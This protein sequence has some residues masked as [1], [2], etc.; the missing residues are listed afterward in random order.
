MDALAHIAW[1]LLF[2]WLLGAALTLVAL[3][4][5]KLL[6]PA[7]QDDSDLRDAPAVSVLVPARDE[8]RRVLAACLGSILAQDYPAF[9]VVAVD[10]RS[11]DATPFI[12]RQVAETDSRL[13]VV[14]GAEPPAGWL[15]KPHALR[16]ALDAADPS[17]EWLLL[18]DADMI[19]HPSA[20]RAAVAR[21]RAARCDALTLVPR[22]EAVTFW[23]RVFVPTWAWG[24]LIL[25]PTELVNRDGWPLPFALGG[26]FLVRRRALERAGGF[27]SVR[28]EVLEDVRLAARLKGAGA[29]IQAEHAPALVSTR[30]YASLAELWEGSTKNWFAVLGFSKLLTAA[31]LLWMFAVGVLPSLLVAVSLAANW[32]RVFWPALAAHALHAGLLALV[33]RRGR[34]PARYGLTAPLGYAL[35]CA[36]LAASAYGVLTGKGVSWKGRRIYRD[37]P[38]EKDKN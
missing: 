15:G 27:D 23:E 13:R 35:S 24:M 8:E 2:V 1:T 19:F 10:D 20:L 36:V 29:R 11:T 5:Q 16:Q 22:F 9:E 31:T 37:G 26:F 28:S 4:R 12:L 3:R 34:I 14:A 25:Y 17:A 30:M 38:D 21:A 33:C 7:P 6:G 18:T 32:T